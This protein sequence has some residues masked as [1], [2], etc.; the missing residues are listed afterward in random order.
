MK[1][2][3]FLTSGGD[4]PGMNACTRA[5]VKSCINQNIVPVGIK[6]GFKGMIENNMQVFTE[7]DVDHII[8]LG[9]TIL[10]TA[11]CQEFKAKEFRLKAIQNLKSKGIDGLVVVGGDGTFTG[12]NLLSQEMNIPIIGIPGTIDNDIFGTDR[13]IG[14]DSAL[15]TVVEA[16]DKIRD[17][18][19]SHHR[20]FF[21]EVMGKNSGYIALNSALASGLEIVLIP[22]LKSDTHIIV[23]QIEKQLHISKSC[24]V[25][26]A[27]GDDGG[28]ATTLIEK[29]KPHL[30]N[31]D[32]R[33]TV[34]GHLQ[35]G[36][37]PSAFDRILA[38]KMGIYAID[39]LLN[40]ETNK[41]I[42]SKGDLLHLIPI[43]DG[44]KYKNT[45]LLT[46]NMKLIQ[47]I[48]ITN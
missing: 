33:S 24:I 4:S 45:P 7:K 14:Y 10:G 3:A 18:A 28:N 25:I 30:H 39:S 36:G 9:G 29:L 41:M 26:V 34:L 47:K 40:G 32:V 5:L 13:C 38:T 8:H 27:E 37:S 19:E 48:L 1:K 15:N 2:I 17:T 42:A 35:R 46:E 44:I 23:S 43:E 11:R 21:V 20:V 31:F 12:A 6:D 16:V 22:E